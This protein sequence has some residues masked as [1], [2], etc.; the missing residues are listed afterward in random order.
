MA[1]NQIIEPIRRLSASE[2]TYAEFAASVKPSGAVNR[3]PQIGNSDPVLSYSVYMNGPTARSLPQGAQEFHYSDASIHALT[4][5]LGLD[6]GSFRDNT[7][8]AELVATRSAWMASV[9]DASVEKSADRLLGVRPKEPS[10]AVV[11]D[12]ELLSKDNWLSHPYV[13]AQLNM[14]KAITRNLEPALSAAETAVGSKVVERVP[15][16]VES[17]TIIS[18]NSDFTVQ[19]IGDGEVVAH[20]NRR[21]GKLPQVGKDVTV[22]Y[23]RGQGQVF[24]NARELNMS[25]PYIDEKTNDLALSFKDKRGEVE[26]VVLFGSLASFQ[27]FVLDHKLGDAV[28]EQAL[29][30]REAQP[31]TAAPQKSP[32]RTPASEIY[33][34][35]KSQAL[36]YDYLENGRKHTVL[37]G[38]AEIVERKAGAFNISPDL[39]AQAKLLGQAKQ[40]AEKQWPNDVDRQSVMIR[41]VAERDRLTRASQI[42]EEPQKTEQMTR[43]SDQGKER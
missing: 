10:A 33:F 15:R 8:V 16:E 31:R 25:A 5:K 43:N 35:D 24:E 30:A 34:D 22:T 12:F 41:Q 14:Q 4:E 9:L 23:Y 6:K 36:A 17:G 40:F 2:M 7:K 3:L 26:E 19:S 13:A 38:D 39:V 27:Q 28:V 32:E 20:E 1:E 42:R 11:R 37:F 29:Q 21:L 18:Q